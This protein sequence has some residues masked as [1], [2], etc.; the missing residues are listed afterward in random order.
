LI[1]SGEV[2]VHRTGAAWITVSSG[3]KRLVDVSLEQGSYTEIRLLTMSSRIV[4]SG[5]TYEL[6]IPSC[7]VKIPAHFEVHPMV[8]SLNEYILL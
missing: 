6:I 5:Q 4:V 7:E 8:G 1:V 2:S 3:Q